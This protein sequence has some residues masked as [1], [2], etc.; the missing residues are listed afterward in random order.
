VSARS[1]RASALLEAARPRQWVKNLLFVAAPVVFA[2][3]LGDGVAVRR[4]LAATAIFCAISSAVYLWNDVIDVERD[5]AHP[6]KSRRP[7]ASGRL[8]IVTAQA[9]AATLAALGLALGYLLDP[10]FAAAAAGYLALNV[11]YSL[12]L[13]RVVYLDVLAIAAGF[14]LRV[15]A[16]AFA[17]AVTASPYLVVCTGLVATFLGLGKRAHELVQAGEGSAAQ[18]PTLK[19][20]RLAELRVALLLVGAATFAAYVLYTRAPH[21]V[22]FF[23]TTRM[24]WTTPFSAFGLGRFWW[25]ALHK[26]SADSPTEEML[27]DPPFVLN[28]LLCA[29][30]TI[31]IIYAGPS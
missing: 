2:K 29:A 8:P 27:T 20:Y 6:R 30:A 4:A 26:K 7:V 28:F 24:I 5:R 31:A 22:A 9:A 14:L 23:Q 11:A 13:K 10:R 19:S 16:G 18:R 15:Q 21:T 3:H 12:W 17:V 25:L 1:Q